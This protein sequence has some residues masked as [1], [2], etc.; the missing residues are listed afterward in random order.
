MLDFSWEGRRDHTEP[1]VLQL[2]LESHTEA[3]QEPASKS[4]QIGFG[5][6]LEHELMLQLQEALQIPPEF[7]LD[8]ET[9]G[10]KLEADFEGILDPAQ[11]EALQ[12]ATSI[13]QAAQASGDTWTCISFRLRLRLRL[14]MTVTIY[15]IL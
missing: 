8:A 15:Y 6:E 1:R 2:E 4:E 10:S 13:F 9:K 3:A 14:T 12:E 5:R 11:L 7:D